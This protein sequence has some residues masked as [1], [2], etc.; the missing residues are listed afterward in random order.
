L[1]QLGFFSGRPRP[2]LNVNAGELD[3][4]VMGA[5]RGFIEV[6][7]VFVTGACLYEENRAGR[8]NLGEK[9]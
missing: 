4:S 1:R 6:N 5:I 3:A 9:D 7:I 8:E 2:G